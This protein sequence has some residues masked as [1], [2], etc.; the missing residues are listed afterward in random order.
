MQ[1]ELST[2]TGTDARFDA[3]L[4]QHRDRWPALPEEAEARWFAER[5]ATL[6]TAAILIQ[7]APAAVSDAYVATRVA[8]ERG[9]I[10][11]AISAV[12]TDAI[13]ARLATAP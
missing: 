3:A 6:L 5:T 11:G 7:S 12:D 1:A 9:Q 10:A 8:G 2:A 13:L 4:K